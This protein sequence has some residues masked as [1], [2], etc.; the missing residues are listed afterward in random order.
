ML[1]QRP[2]SMKAKFKDILPLIERKVCPW[3]RLEVC[4]VTVSLV[5]SPVC[6][7]MPS[8]PP[9]VPSVEPPTREPRVPVWP[10]PCVSV[11]T[12]HRDP[13]RPMWRARWV[14]EKLD[15]SDTATCDTH[16][17]SFCGVSTVNPFLHLHSE[18]LSA[19]NFEIT[20]YILSHFQFEIVDISAFTICPGANRVRP[21]WILATRPRRTCSK[22]Y[23]HCNF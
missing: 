6:R 22:F 23:P 12:G 10:R 8:I 20:T 21:G 4:R 15:S 13:P 9:R 7:P 1:C 2:L 18:I 14:E 17:N 3:S 5:A 11:Y 16:W 19:P